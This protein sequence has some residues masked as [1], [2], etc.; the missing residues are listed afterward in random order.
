MQD[1]LR[2][3]AGAGNGGEIQAP[4][5]EAVPTVPA[6]LQR[7]LVFP[8]IQG[9]SFARRVAREGGYSA[10]NEAFLRPPKSSREVLHPEEFISRSF[11]P[12]E[13]STEE[14]ERPAAKTSLDYADTVGEFVIS[15]ILADAL[16]SQSRGE[17]CAQGWKRDRV[18]AFSGDAGA[19]FISWMTEWESST[20]AGQFFECYREMLKVR[21]KRDVHEDLVP[22]SLHKKMKIARH[23]LRIS[24]VVEVVQ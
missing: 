17:E 12:G 3:R 4:A 5:S 16:T 19:H 2:G 14:I 10:L 1:F 7:V 11:V 23:D 8:Y 22:V 20:E 13:L 21:Y 9:L 18:A 24:V 6:A 15:A